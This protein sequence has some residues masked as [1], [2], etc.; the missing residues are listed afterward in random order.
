MD[1]AVSEKSILALSNHARRE[2]YVCLWK[3]ASPASY[4][5][6]LEVDNIEGK[7]LVAFVMALNEKFAF[8]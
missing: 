2:L 6:L 7:S 1:V 4:P 8:N 3:E 5:N